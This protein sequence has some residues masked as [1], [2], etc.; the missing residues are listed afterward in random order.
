MTQRTITDSEGTQWSF[1]Q[2]LATSGDTHA[3]ARHA[4]NTSGGEQVVVVATPSGGAQSI[5]LELP[6]TWSESMD[7]DALTDLLSGAG[8]TGG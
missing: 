4:H 6:P 1:A 7:D 3:D 8:Q 2:T 5:R